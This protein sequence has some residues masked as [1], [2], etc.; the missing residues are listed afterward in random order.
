MMAL[1]IS[2]AGKPAQSVAG[3]VGAGLGKLV[4]ET[5]AGQC[6][7]HGGFIDKHMRGMGGNANWWM[8]CP[9]CRSAAQQAQARREQ[10]EQMARDKA[11]AA[12]AR[13]AATAAR[14]ASSG[15]P[16]RFLAATW[17]GYRT[18]D[19]AGEG[20]GTQAYALA[21]CR[22]YADRFADDHLPNG[23]A[24]LL[25]GN[26]GTGKNHLATC[27]ARHVAEAGHSVVFTTAEQMLMAWRDVVVH[28][29]PGSRGELALLRDFASPDLLILDE[30]FR[31]GDSA[32][33]NRFL[34]E[35]LNARYAD[36]L[37]TIICSN[38]TM[39]EMQALLDPVLVDRL[40]ERAALVVPFPWE[41]VR[42]KVGRGEG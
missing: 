33:A 24:L 10:A 41:S 37:P 34:F 42:G 13:A 15:V 9:Q 6:A 17:E 36:A 16:R 40:R 7:Q 31:Q 2:D 8:G 32:A 23:R 22:E 20:V 28:K 29:V 26:Q 39:D 1:Q 27:I 25:L 18:T 21:K 14:F 12:Q 3:M 30:M 5:K 4:L 38:K 11:Q 35:V 19:T